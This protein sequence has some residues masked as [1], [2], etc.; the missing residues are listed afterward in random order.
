MSPDSPA[1][2]AR[3]AQPWLMPE[4]VAR[5]I[6]VEVIPRMLVSHRTGAL[7]PDQ[8]SDAARLLDGG[9]V[10]RLVE[11]L[12]GTGEAETDLFV[13]MLV[14]EGVA[15]EAIY[16]DLLAPAARMLGD[17]WSEDECD[18]VEV[19][20]AL[21]RMQRILRSLSHLFLAGVEEKAAVGRVL[22]AG[23]PGEQHTLGLFMVAEFFVRDGWLVT[24][25]PPFVDDDLSKLL[26]QEWFDLVGFSVGCDSRLSV[27]SRE[28]GRVRRTSRN[29]GVRVLV[30]GRIFNDR[31][32]MVARVGADGTAADG[33]EAPG[34]A[35]ALIRPVVE[36][37]APVTK[38]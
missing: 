2:I 12:R 16:L 1:P 19:S 18:F 22:L 31:P 15:S 13:E 36:R 5:T 20:I 26:R 14:Q 9:D 34:V 7:S 29:R 33:R 3:Q 24:I 10:E 35:A 17:L 11:L 27:L 30:G 6:E 38:S 21:G 23:A 32:E 28:I 8:L 4:E 37:R 25:G